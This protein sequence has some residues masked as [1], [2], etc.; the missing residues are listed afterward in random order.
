MFTDRYLTEFANRKLKENPEYDGS[1][2][3]LKV[4]PLRGEYELQGIRL[5]KNGIRDQPAVCEIKSA[6]ARISGAALWQ[7]V[8]ATRVRV[9]GFKLNLV[10]PKQSGERR[11][12]VVPAW[13]ERAKSLFPIRVDEL[14]LLDGA[15][16]LMFPAARP[17]AALWVDHIQVNGRNL[18]NRGRLRSEPYA[19]WDLR[20]DFLGTAPLQALL[21]TNVLSPTPAFDIKGRLESLAL[22]GLNAFLHAFANLDAAHGV[23]SMKFALTLNEGVITGYVEPSFTDLAV[24]RWNKGKAWSTLKRMRHELVTRGI[25]SL[26]DDREVLSMRIPIRGRL[27][28]VKLDLPSAVLSVLKNAFYQALDP[29]LPRIMRR[30]DG[31]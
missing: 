29:V 7:R 14:S 4:H 5:E 28:D 25:E 11:P 18:T 3:S 22:P 1:V 6:D 23:L 30:A 13:I 24:S 2:D 19:Q 15:L 20:A 31:R 12:G 9:N 21:R 16:R 26:E 17:P 8:L 10:A 27:G